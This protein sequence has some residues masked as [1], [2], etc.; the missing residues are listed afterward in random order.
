MKRLRSLRR[1]FY[2]VAGMRMGIGTIAKYAKMLG[3]GQNRS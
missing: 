1:S 3:L 2:D